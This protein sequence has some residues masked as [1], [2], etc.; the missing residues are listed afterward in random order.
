M[1]NQKDNA[2]LFFRWGKKRAS[3]NFVQILFS[4]P[5]VDVNPVRECIPSLS[6]LSLLQQ[7]QLRRRR[8]RQFFRGPKITAPPCPLLPPERASLGESGLAT[9]RLA[10][11]LRASYKKTR[12]ISL[13]S[14]ISKHPRCLSPLY[15]YMPRANEIQMR[16]KGD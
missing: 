1:R 3:F 11:H 5:P 8:R 14:P 10:E 2:H 9:G 16:T 15:M 6:F 7:Q 4:P 13:S 12:C